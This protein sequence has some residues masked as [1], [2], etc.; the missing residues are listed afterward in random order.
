MSKFDSKTNSIL[1]R[2]GY[3]YVD[4]TSRVINKNAM[5]A[6]ATI[7]SNI[8]YYGYSL[9]SEAYKALITLS[10]KELEQWWS[11]IEPIFKDITGDNR[12]IGDFVVYKNFPAEVLN[13]SEAQYWFSQILMYWGVPNELFTEEVQERKDIS[14]KEKKSLNFFN[15]K[16]ENSKTLENIYSSLLKSPVAWKNSEAD[17]VIHLSSILS[18]DISK[19]PFKENLVSLAT[20]AI[21]NNIP[22]KINTATDVLRIGAALSNADFSLKTKVKF[23]SFSKKTRRYLLKNLNSCNNIKEDIARRKNVWKKFLHQLHAGDYKNKYSKV[24]KVQ[25]E[26]YNDE[27][28]SFSSDVERFIKIKDASAL[29]LLE[30]RPGEFSRRIVHMVDVFGEDAVASFKN[31]I[32]KL[33][34]Q[35]IVS[36]RNH[37]DNANI[38][39]HRVFPPKGNWKKLQ[40]GEARAIDTKLAY[41]L[42][43]ALGNELKVRV[44]KIKFLDP[45]IAKV[46]LPNNGSDEGKYNRGTIFR[47]PKDIKFIRTASYWEN[48]SYCNSWFD[49]GWNFFSKKWNSLGACCWNKPVF[50]DR[51]AIF[52][53]DPTN[54][55]EMNGKAAQMI[56]LYPERLRK[57]GVRYAVWNVLCYSKITFSKATDVFAALQWGVEPQSGKLF[58]PSRCQL[59]FKLE[60]DYYTK[61]ICMIDL[62]KNE[63]MYIDANLKSD[64]TSSA[65]NGE[66]L[67][68]TMPAFIEYIKSL[69]SVYDLFKE[70][71]DSENG[72]GYVVYTDKDILFNDKQKAYVFQQIADNNIDPINLNA[73]LNS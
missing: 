56:D 9:S 43:D 63:M 33:S 14:D 10:D 23:A 7:I 26:L 61:Y 52:S 39:K 53:G 27:L 2:N 41:D 48:K 8:S 57:S 65:S 51:G 4:N 3:I 59:S 68:K 67:E 17:D 37:I 11:N 5:Q 6:I 69:P 54:S 38:R 18:T 30:T 21:K 19:I 24:L 46:T 32:P 15:L 50:G 36:L 34:V 71:V 42:F 44:P 1:L 16:L 22:I 49:N 12:N 55:K 58:E 25:D 28:T 47:I 70:S 62:E 72:E 13:K 64:I 20:I 29:S 31:I 35:K 40:I 73:I 45:N 66:V 60:G